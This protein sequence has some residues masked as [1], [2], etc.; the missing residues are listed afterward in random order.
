MVEEATDSVTPQ[1]KLALG[2]QQKELVH[3]S[4]VE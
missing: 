2:A 3:A 1:A 4:C